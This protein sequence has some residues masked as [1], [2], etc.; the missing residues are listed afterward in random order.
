MAPRLLVL[1]RRARRGPVLPGRRLDAAAV[2]VVGACALGVASAAC[3]AGAG[4]GPSEGGRADGRGAG[5]PPQ[6]PF[7]PESDGAASSVSRLGPARGCGADAGALCALGEVCRTDADCASGTCGALGPARGLCVSARSC[8]GTRGADHRCGLDGGGDCCGSIR[9]PGGAFVMR[10]RT[11]RDA[12]AVVLPFRLDRFEITVGRLRAFFDAKGG[13]VRGE[14]PGEGEAEHPLVSGSGWRASWNEELPASFTEIDARMT[15]ACDAHEPLEPYHAGAPWAATTWTRS[16]GAG[17]DKPANCID[18]YTLFAFCA[19]DGGRLPTDAEWSYVAYGGAEQRAYPWGN[20]PPVFETHAHVVAT[21]LVAPGSG[22]GRYTEGPPLWSPGDGA[23]HIA[24]VGKKTGRSRWGHADMG[25]NVMEMVADEAGV[26]GGSVGR[27]RI[28]RGSSWRGE[29][30]G[31]ALANDASRH[32]SAAR[33]TSSA[34]GARCAR[35]V[36]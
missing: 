9:V 12:R 18:W 30:A 10:D 35:D 26:A 7:G 6:R 15:T 22:Y 36:P 29:I 5:A 28:A 33:S 13:D 21:S 1:P 24:P 2:A 17:D 19:W 23:A 16:P 31:H 32:V 3:G 8:V 27:E 34:V 14:P 25:G 4:G 11:G 20:D